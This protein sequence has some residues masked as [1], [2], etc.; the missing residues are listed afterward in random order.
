MDLFGGT[1]GVI[2]MVSLLAITII[3]ILYQVWLIRYV[4]PLDKEEFEKVLK[5]LHPPKSD[6]I[7]KLIKDI[8]RQRLN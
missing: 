7:F 8:F 5:I 2:I 4:R 1:G 3:K 6:G